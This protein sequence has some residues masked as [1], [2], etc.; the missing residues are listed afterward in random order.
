MRSHTGRRSRTPWTKPTCMSDGSTVGPP[1][2]G[3]G[4]VAEG[5]HRL[6]A[7]GRRASSCSDCSARAKRAPATRPT[8]RP[9]GAGGWVAATVRGPSTAC[10]TVKP[11]LDRGRG[12]PEL[13]AVMAEIRLPDRPGEEGVGGRPR[14][15]E[16]LGQRMRELPAEEAAHERHDEGLGEGAVVAVTVVDRQ[17][18]PDV[19][20]EDRGGQGADPVRGGAAEIGVEH[21]EAPAPRAAGRRSASCAPPGPSRARRPRRGRPRSARITRTGPRAAASAA[22]VSSD[23]AWS[24]CTTTAAWPAKCA[25]RPA[26]TAP[27]H[28]RDGGA[29]PGGGQAHH[30][31]GGADPLDGGPD[32]VGELEGLHHRVR[33]ASSAR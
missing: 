1:G 17:H 22:G 10:P 23:G 18:E 21:H 24:T 5:H 29:R 13:E 14:A 33:W 32:L 11:P 30:E 27:R 26:R 2:S 25:S 31:V 16:L 8:V 4:G 15:G 20:L 6:R 19:V 12:H 9:S 7:R 28:R 3:S